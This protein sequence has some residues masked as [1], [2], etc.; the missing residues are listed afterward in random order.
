MT[1]REFSS[2]LRRLGYDVPQIVISTWGAPTTH[3]NKVTRRARV[4]RWIR[5]K[6][7]VKFARNRL[8]PEFLQF[9][10]R[11][12]RETRAPQRKPVVQERRVD[13]ARKEPSGKNA[14]GG[15]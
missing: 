5:W 13:R 7:H 3:G 2:K 12:K 1:D 10:D 14:L 6:M 8:V 11:R 15:K 4:E 9:F